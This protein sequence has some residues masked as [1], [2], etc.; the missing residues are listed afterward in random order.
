MW[1][2]FQDSLLLGGSGGLSRNITWQ[3]ISSDVYLQCKLSCLFTQKSYLDAGAALCPLPRSQHEIVS[4]SVWCLKEWGGKTP[5]GMSKQLGS[6]LINLRR[7]KQAAE[8]NAVAS[9]MQLDLHQTR[10]DLTCLTMLFISKASSFT[11]LW[12]ISCLHR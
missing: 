3:L 12:L 10:K 2:T 6:K 8:L 1:K 5:H 4:F 11:S 9:P 7:L